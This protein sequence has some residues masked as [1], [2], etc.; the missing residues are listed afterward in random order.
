[1]RHANPLGLEGADAAAIAL[2]EKFIAADHRHGNYPHVEV[3]GFGGPWQ[4]LPMV[5]RLGC[6]KRLQSAA[7]GFDV[8]ICPDGKVLASTGT[9]LNDGATLV[10]PTS[11]YDCDACELK[12]RCCPKMP[13]AR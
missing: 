7:P 3:L 8:Y 13:S 12:P 1:M 6:D 10:Y 4:N 11:K 2:L 9:L 5:P